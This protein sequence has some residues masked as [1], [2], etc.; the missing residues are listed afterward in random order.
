MRG[1]GHALALVACCVALPAAAAAQDPP[2][3]PPRFRADAFLDPVAREIYTIAYDGWDALGETIERYTARIDQRFSVGVRALLR[4]RVLYHSETSVRAFWERDRRAIIQVLGSRAQYPGRDIARRAHAEDDPPEPFWLEEFPFNEP[5]EPGSDQLFGESDRR[6]EPFQPTDDDF[7]LAH[8][9]GEGADSLYR[10]RSGD[11][12][13]L[14][15][16]DGQRFEAVQLDVLPRESDPHLISGT[17]WIDAASGALARAVYRLA[18]PVEAARDIPGFREDVVETK[19]AFVPGFLVDVTFEMKMIAVDYSLWD[20]EVWLPRTIRIEGEVRFAGMV[21]VPVAADYRYRIESVTM[22]G[23]LEAGAQ[24]DALGVVALKDVR[25]DTREEAMAFIMQLLSEDGEP[26]YEPLSDDFGRGTNLIAPVDPEAI[27]ESPYLPPP[28]WEDAPGF[29]SDRDLEQYIE[30]LA[31]LPAAPAAHALWNFNWGWSQTDLVRYN[32]VEGPAVGGRVSW[33][34]LG[35]YRFGASGFFG[36]A[37]LRPKVR[38]DIERATVLR[39]LKLGAYHELRPT[40][41]ESGYLGMG[42]SVE[43]FFYGRD[44]GEYYEATGADLSWRPPRIALQSFYARV[45]GELQRPAENHTDFAL[46]RA[47]DRGWDFRENVAADEVEEVGGELRLSPWWGQDPAGARLGVE[48]FGRGAAWR[49]P[50][51][52]TRESYGQ[53]S[54]MVQAIV[55]VSGEGWQRWRVGIEAAGGNTWGQAPVQRSWFLGSAASVRGFPAST[56]SGPSFLRGRLEVGRTYEGFAASLFG[57]AGWAGPV[58]EFDLDD[59]LYGVG[60]G[61]SIM[62]GFIRLDFSQGL[63]GPRRQFRVELYLDAIL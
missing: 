54:A 44:N 36:F 18:R 23:D 51:E 50:G 38:L 14:D 60:V 25:F 35:P 24:P 40:D 8:P 45:Y 62:D 9:L 13:T 29:P 3:E 55:P 22:T 17:L 43:A 21:K 37:D 4:K 39:R 46:F 32:R 59:L 42:N 12:I 26:A 2:P 34:V 11:T 1:A 28:I 7:W 47:F 52:E 5:F 33:P 58:G 30:G 31:N 61:G 57:D 53:A 19:P 63:K 20:F 41:S 10:F 6:A 16:P 48:L 56:L 27:E 15:F 49:R